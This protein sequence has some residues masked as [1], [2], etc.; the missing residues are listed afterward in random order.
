MPLV[1]LTNWPPKVMT[2]VVLALLCMMCGL[3]TS[4][5][6]MLG[7]SNVVLALLCTMSGLAA[8]T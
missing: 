6:S 3:E 8:I 5:E 2:D 1:A 7:V 4:R